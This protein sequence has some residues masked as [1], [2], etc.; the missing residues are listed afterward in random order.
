ML[1]SATITFLSPAKK[2][3][4][5]NLSIPD[6]PPEVLA[7]NALTAN[8]S[9]GIS[10]ILRLPADTFFAGERK[11]IVADI[12]NLSQIDDIVSSA[13]AKFNCFNFS[14]QTNDVI[15]STREAELSQT[16]TEETA[17]TRRVIDTTEVVTIID[18]PP[19][20]N[21]FP[22]TVPNNVPNTV[23]FPPNEGNTP[24]IRPPGSNNVGGPG[25][26]IHDA[27]LFLSLIHI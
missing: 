11:V 27:P 10:G 4:A 26:I 24:G 14:V 1:I 9:G 8:T 7:V 17:N 22:N 21:Q 6:I 12:S 19:G 15:V 20:G 3:S 18:P 16:R 23:P 2:V 5:G 13:S 25:R